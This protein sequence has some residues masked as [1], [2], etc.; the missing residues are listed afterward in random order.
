MIRPFFLVTAVLV[1]ALLVGCASDVKLNE[2]PVVKRNPVPNEGQDAAGGI[3]Q[4]E[5]ASVDLTAQGADVAAQRIIYFELDSYIIK[6]E[7]RTI[8][9]AQ[10]RRLTTD[11][12]AKLVIEGHTDNRGGSEYN[13][14]LGQRRAESVMKALILLGVQDPQLEAVSFGKERPAMQ[15]NDETAWARNRRAELKER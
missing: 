2:T 3:S 5:V 12:N 8:V 1:S 4:S 11:R 6:P 10:A 7:Y 9:E 13:L 15:G 14:A